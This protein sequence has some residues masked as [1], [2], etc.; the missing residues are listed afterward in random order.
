MKQIFEME[1][2]R[3]VVF[4]YLSKSLGTGASRVAG[5]F[6]IC[7]RVLR[8]NKNEKTEQRRIF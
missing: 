1:G 3:H 5:D 8:E 6:D 4:N 7:T 2:N